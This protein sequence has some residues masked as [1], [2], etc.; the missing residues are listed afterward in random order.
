MAEIERIIEIDAPPEAVWRVLLDFDA[1]AEWNPFIRSISGHPEPG[2]TLTVRLEPPGGRRV[3]IKP[4]VVAVEPERELR[5]QGRLLVRG[6]F[7]GEHTLRIEPTGEGRTRFVHR[8]QFRGVLVG[9]LK[10]VLRKT[11]NGFEQMNAALKKRVE[12]G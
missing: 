10:G 3:T 7:D 6:L 4:K 1:Y 8:E 11:A 9:L 2:E 12:S 5:W